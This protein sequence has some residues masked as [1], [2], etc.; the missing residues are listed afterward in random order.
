MLT[1][2]SCIAE[3]LAWKERTQNQEEGKCLPFIV[4]KVI[5]WAMDLINSGFL[6]A[7]VPCPQNPTAIQQFARLPPMFPACL[8]GQTAVARSCWLLPLKTEWQLPFLQCQLNFF[9]VLL[10][11]LIFMETAGTCTLQTFNLLS[12]LVEKLP[13]SYYGQEAQ[14]DEICFIRNLG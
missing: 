13:R 7:G 14:L 10:T 1:L 12:D 8:M 3:T 2:D 11:R 4:N 5:P 6:R 9:L